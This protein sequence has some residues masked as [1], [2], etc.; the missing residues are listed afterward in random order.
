[1][2]YIHGVHAFDILGDPVR[3]RIVEL[4]ANGERTA[5]DISAIVQR[6]FGISQP[7]V[8]QQLRTL[9]DSGFATVR[10]EGTRRMYVMDPTPLNEIADWVDRARRHWEESFDSLDTHLARVQGKTRPR[11]VKPLRRK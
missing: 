7:A 3:R 10:P 8:S 2:A 6:E 9:R 5:G 4:L 11:A 1:M